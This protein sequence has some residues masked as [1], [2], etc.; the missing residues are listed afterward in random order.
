MKS[1][2]TGKKVLS[3]I[4]LGYVGLTMAVGFG[5]K[6]YKVIGIDIDN[7]KVDSLNRGILYIYEDGLA[8]ALKNISMVATSNFDEILGSDITFVCVSTPSNPD[9]SANFNDVKNSVEQLVEVLKKKEN[10]HLIVV[11][12][13]MIPG[14]T[15][16]VLIPIVK[17][18]DECGICVNP[19]FLREGSALDDFMKSS[20]IIIGEYDKKSGDIL[21]DLYS[22]FDCP[23]LRTDIKTAEMIKYASNAFLA[24][25]LS[26]I[27]EIGNICKKMGIDIYE[28]AEGMGYD[29]RIG[30]KFLDAGIGF[31]GSCL[32]KDVKALVAKSKEIGYEP[33]V[34]EAVLQLNDQQ[35]L[36]M[37]ELLKKYMSLRGRTIGIL[38]LAFKPGTD[39]I[40]ESKAIAIIEA[41]LKEGA[42]VKAYDPQAI[43]NFRKIF[44]QIEYVS[45]E[46]VLRSDAILILTEWSEF[47]EL[48]YTG[49]IVIDGRR[50]L[51]AKE[52]KIYEG[53]CW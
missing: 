51:K 25:K 27:N 46:E 20:R 49:K 12:S 6:G 42:W 9:G 47:N 32:P 36:R 23:I 14:T 28:V 33:K 44:P 53:V 29:E 10:Y 35:P 50:I 34:L 31:G 1:G 3:V 8:E 19:E 18:L 41:L 52:A 26:F 2:Y 38:G 40:R 7:E 43:P 21:C 30:D 24:A 39:D 13:T 37:I 15:E 5:L 4:G 45:P 16:A 11:R 17:A 48:D 22:S